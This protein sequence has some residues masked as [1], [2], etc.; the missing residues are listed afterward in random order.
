MSDHPPLQGIRVL[1]FTQL[2]PGPVCT[3]Y[4]ADL[5]AEVIKIEPPGPGDPVRG[6]THY[7]HMF[8]LLNR[9]K[10]SLQVDLNDA[11]EQYLVQA[12][13]KT[14]DVVVEGFRPGVAERLGIGWKQL[15][16]INPKL[17]YCSITGYGQDGPLAQNAGHDI[18]YQCLAGTLEQTGS[19]GGA[20]AQ[21]NLPVAD[22]A[23]GALSALGG[24][25]A[26]LFAAERSGRGRHVD[27]AMSDCL[28][29]LNL[30]VSVSWQSSGRVPPRGEDFL[31]G[32]LACYR[33][34]QTSDQRWLAVGAVE[35]KFW[36]AFCEVIARPDLADKGHVYGEA[37][38]E[39]AASIA[40]IIASRDLAYWVDAFSRV[41]AC[42]TPV[43]RIDEVAEHPHT[44]ARGILRR[45]L[46]PLGGPYIRHACPLRMGDAPWPEP[47]PAPALGADNEAIRRELG[48]M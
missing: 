11:E 30:M 25:L 33:S 41:D 45:D 21:G 48:L 32:A 13:A 15:S 10:R 28:L 31:S 16:A 44:R 20:P 19:A 7:S 34:Y 35:H 38:M 9:N 26:A 39:A 18:N 3:L 2:L 27:I 23:G 29:A 4:L 22:L 47:T 12:L 24:I 42:V 37:G 8:M 36:R 43:L 5:G 17:V 46:H 40:G 14:A 1:D 6:S